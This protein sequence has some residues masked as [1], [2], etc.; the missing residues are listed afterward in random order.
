MRKKLFLAVIL[1]ILATTAVALF[2][3]YKDSFNSSQSQTPPNQKEEIPTIKL[4][5]AGIIGSVVTIDENELVITTESGNITLDI[6]SPPGIYM[7]EGEER[8]DKSLKDIRRGS[9]VKV[10]YLVSTNRNVP[11]TIEIDKL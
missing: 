7:M 2:F 4:E 6:S 9:S 10:Y 3:K 11:I 8:I 5:S 1:V